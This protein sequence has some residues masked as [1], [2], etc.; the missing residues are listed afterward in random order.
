M[1]PVWRKS[2]F[3]S[4]FLNDLYLSVRYQ[5]DQYLIAEQAKFWPGKT[6]VGQVL[7]LTQFI[8]DRFEKWCAIG[9]ISRTSAYDTV[10]HKLLLNKVYRMTNDYKL[11]EIL[12]LILQ[13]RHFTIRSGNT[14]SRWRKQVNSIP[15]GSS[16][17]HLCKWPT[18]SAIYKQ[19]YQCK[20]SG[21]NRIYQISRSIWILH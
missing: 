8:E 21:K 14:V 7:N 2:I 13:N 6:C 20:W 9:V 10:N 12:R 17:Q 16:F 18:E 3:V 4:N 5:V 19:V 1:P 11:T 15:R